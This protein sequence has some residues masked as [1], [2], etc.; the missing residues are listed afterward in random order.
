M[1]TSAVVTRARQ[2][3]KIFLLRDMGRAP[4]RS[5]QARH[6]YELIGHKWGNTGPYSHRLIG[7]PIIEVHRIAC[8]FRPR[9][10]CVAVSAVA[11]AARAPHGDGNVSPTLFPARFLRCRPAPFYG[12]RDTEIFELFARL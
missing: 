10:N 8:A 5:L 4:P 7:G 2:R 1:T 11:P 3:R 12:R 6:I 9:R